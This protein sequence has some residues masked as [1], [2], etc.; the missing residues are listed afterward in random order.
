MLLISPNEKVCYVN[1]KVDVYNPN[2]TSSLKWELIGILTPPNNLEV[3][4]TGIACAKHLKIVN[5][6]DN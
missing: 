3:L 2:E 4:T 6:P 5:Q 1:L